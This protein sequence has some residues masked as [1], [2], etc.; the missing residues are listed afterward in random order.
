MTEQLN[1]L[2]IDADNLGTKQ[3]ERL[4]GYNTLLC[5]WFNKVDY[6]KKYN[7]HHNLKYFDIAVFT[8][9]TGGG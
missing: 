1:K 8:G 6:K 7:L 3:C 2:S 9:L 5:T 4:S